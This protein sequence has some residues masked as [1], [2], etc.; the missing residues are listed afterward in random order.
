MSTR[1]TSA[2]ARNWYH[3]VAKKI[4]GGD[5]ENS[6]GNGG[7]MLES[8]KGAKTLKELALVMSVSVDSD[9]FEKDEEAMLRFKLAID[10]EEIELEVKFGKLQHC[11]QITDKR[12]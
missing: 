11:T 4:A 9:I 1:E 12:S 7:I 6:K 3:S 5:E 2:P 10:G 8:V